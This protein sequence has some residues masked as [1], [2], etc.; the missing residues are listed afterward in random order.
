MRNYGTKLIEVNG[1]DPVCI[2]LTT[3]RE[4]AARGA[5]EAAME[6]QENGL[7]VGVVEVWDHGDPDDPVTRY[8]WQV[9]LSVPEDWDWE[10]AMPEM[11]IAVEQQA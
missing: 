7:Y 3:D 8:G 4:S 6:K 2:I 10:D 1:D 11:E 9:E 5:V